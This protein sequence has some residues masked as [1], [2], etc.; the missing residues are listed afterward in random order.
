MEDEG[1]R[2]R[3]TVRQEPKK[4][5][6]GNILDSEGNINKSRGKVGIMS[7]PNVKQDGTPMTVEDIKAKQEAEK[8]EEQKNIRLRNEQQK[9]LRFEMQGRLDEYKP[10]NEFANHPMLQHPNATNKILTANKEAAAANPEK[11]ATKVEEGEQVVTTQTT[12]TAVSPASKVTDN[13]QQQTQ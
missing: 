5:K 7:N 1:F 8:Q 6:Y 4:D 11:T 2:M 12:E 3:A 10:P 9:M 13:N